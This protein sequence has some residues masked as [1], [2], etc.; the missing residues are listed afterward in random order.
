M[1][2]AAEVVVRN[3]R[4]AGVVR[5]DVQPGDLL[6]MAHGIGVA[7]ETAPDTLDRIFAIMLD[8]LRPTD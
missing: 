8:G 6:R 2:K 7:T 4:E 3:A 1:N 5:T